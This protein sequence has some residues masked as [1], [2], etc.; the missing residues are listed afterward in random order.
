MLQPFRAKTESEKGSGF[1]SFALEPLWLAAER[2]SI[3]AFEVV[4]K[5]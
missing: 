3:P 1:L 2:S 5:A 4:V